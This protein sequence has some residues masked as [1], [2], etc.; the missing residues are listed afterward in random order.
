MTY[1]KKVDENQK[2][3]ISALRA[4]GATVFDASGIGKGFPDLVVGKN[5]QTVLVEVKSGPKKK[6]T[7]AQLDFINK[8]RGGTIHR[9]DSVDGAIRLIKMLDMMTV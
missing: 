6:F 2:I 5:N 1:A 9:I 8:W 7:E 3:I 4:L